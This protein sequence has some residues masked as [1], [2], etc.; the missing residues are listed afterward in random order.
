MKNFI[1]II[2]RK[3]WQLDRNNVIELCAKTAK[4]FYEDDKYEG[5][6]IAEE[7]RKLKDAESNILRGR[8]S[9]DDNGVNGSSR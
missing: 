4:E 7:I 3:Y 5:Q 2:R 1:E 8:C 9:V 6:Q